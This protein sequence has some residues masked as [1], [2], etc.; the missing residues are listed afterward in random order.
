MREPSL[1]QPPDHAREPVNVSVAD[2]EADPH[3][4]FRRY[5]AVAPFIRRDDGVV[6]VLR[7]RDVDSLLIDPRTRQVETELVRL[8]GITHGPV[9][10][11][12]RYSMLTSN[13][14]DHRRRRAS[15]NKAFAASIIAG[16]RP[17]IR[18]LA[19]DLIQAKLGDGEM[20]FLEDY[21]AQV[22]ARVISMI[23]GVPADDVPLFTRWV[24]SFSRVLGSQWTPAFASE[25]ETAAEEL[26]AY[27]ARLLDRRRRT[28]DDDFLS[29]YVAALDAHHELSPA[30]AVAQVASVIVGGSDTTR[31]AIASQVSLLL[32]HREQWDAVCRDAARIPGAVTEA[33]RFEPSIASVPRFS[34]EEIEIDGYMVPA[35]TAMSLSTMS[36]LRDPGI[37]ADP[38]RFDIGRTDHPRRQL[39][40]GGGAHNCLGKALAWMELEESL[41]AI[42]ERLPHLH[43]LEGPLQFQGHAGIRRPS[44]MRVAWGRHQG[45]RGSRT[46]SGSD[47]SLNARRLSDRQNDA[48]QERSRSREAGSRPT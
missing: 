15:M 18:R 44:S 20:D 39:V 12:F 19:D 45:A 31:A 14:A 10:D 11:F 38:D 37:Y 42:A 5:R 48:D 16:L 33:L 40:F 6:L 41:A 43:L 1:S 34:I 9:Y 27:V 8:R 3:G 35:N 28:P 21:A 47:V 22:P 25:A 30:E 32:Q 36:A 4:A 26:T 24:Y 7:G 17:R 29:S 2:L 46:W 13:G 23:L